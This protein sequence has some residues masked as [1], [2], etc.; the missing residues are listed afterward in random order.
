MA[1]SS[2]RKRVHGCEGEAMPGKKARQREQKAAG[3]GQRGPARVFIA[4]AVV[5]SLLAAWTILA[6]SGAFDFI[7]RQKGKRGQGFSTASFNSS[8]RQAC[9]D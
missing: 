4:I 6:Y 9:R 7:L 3:I 8:G 2:L 1:W 5:L